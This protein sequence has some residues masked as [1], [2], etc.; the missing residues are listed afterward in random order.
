MSF[1]VR[2]SLL[3]K[4]KEASAALFRRLLSTAPSNEE[5]EEEEE[6]DDFSTYTLTVF[7]ERSEE[8][9]AAGL[10]SFIRLIGKFRWER[11]I[12]TGGMAPP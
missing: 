12:H 5:E 11:P 8:V 10:A 6:Q 7:S 1:A 2:A 3:T 9:D 4:D